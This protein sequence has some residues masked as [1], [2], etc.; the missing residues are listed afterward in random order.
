M[1]FV[2]VENMVDPNI[3]TVGERHN[4]TSTNYRLT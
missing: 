2:I 1:S 3:F 4:F